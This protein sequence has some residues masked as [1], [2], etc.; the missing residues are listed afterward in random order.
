[1][2]AF[3]EIVGPMLGYAAIGGATVGAFCIH[4]ASKPTL[5]SHSAGSVVIGKDYMR[6]FR[7]THRHVKLYDA[8]KGPGLYENQEMISFSLSEKIFGVPIP[9]GRDRNDPVTY[10]IASVPP[11]AKIRI[12]AQRSGTNVVTIIDKVYL[13]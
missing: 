11:D 6:R 3:A 9:Q 8:W 1:M 5:S 13:E 10:K 12:K 2:K 7:Q 4:F